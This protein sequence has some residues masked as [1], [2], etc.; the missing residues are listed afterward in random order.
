MATTGPGNR[1]GRRWTP[2]ERRVL[3]RVASE[4]GWEWTLR[5]A[6]RILDEAR[7]IEGDLE[8]AR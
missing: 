4:K 2:G 7:M 6:E 8:A 5:Q 1:G 3:E